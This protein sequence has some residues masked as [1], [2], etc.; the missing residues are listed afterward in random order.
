LLETGICAGLAVFRN[1]NKNWIFQAEP[2]KVFNLFGHCGA[3][4][5]GHSG[6]LG[7]QFYD[8]VH[9]L[10]ETYFQNRV[11]FVNNQHL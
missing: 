7:Q 5:A 9:F 3:E 1:L 11:C 6:F 2:A 4:Q 10:L 8:F